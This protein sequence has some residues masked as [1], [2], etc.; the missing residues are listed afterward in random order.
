[1]YQKSPELFEQVKKLIGELNNL[2]CSQIYDGKYF[3]FELFMFLLAD[4]K[5]VAIAKWKEEA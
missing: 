4:D 3:I 2:N 5:E 1:M